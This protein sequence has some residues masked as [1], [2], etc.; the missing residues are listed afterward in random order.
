MQYQVAVELLAFCCIRVVEVA[1][2]LDLAPPGIQIGGILVLLGAG[3]DGAGVWCAWRRPGSS[4]ASSAVSRPISRVLLESNWPPVGPRC[5]FR[6][7]LFDLQF[8]FGTAGLR[9]PAAWLPAVVPAGGAITELRVGEGLEVG[10][11]LSADSTEGRFGR[12]VSPPPAWLT[13]ARKS[14]FSSSRT[15]FVKV[16][17][18][19]GDF[20]ALLAMVQ[21]F[22]SPEN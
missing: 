6:S 4:L 15:L 2:A 22:C 12:S 17:A 8:A 21:A 19:H 11:G 5:R 10:I 7:G 14:G 18:D 3:A 13:G 1:D 20:Q 16:R 9:S